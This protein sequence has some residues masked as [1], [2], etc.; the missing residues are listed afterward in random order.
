MMDSKRTKKPERGGPVAVL[1]RVGG[2]LLSSKAFLRV[3]SVVAALVVWLFMMASDGTLTRRKTF[4]NAAVSVS[5]ESAL[6]TRGYIVTDNLNAILPTVNMTV[7]VTQNNY[8]R[9]NAASY[10]PHIEL[11]HITGEGEFELPIIPT[12]QVYGQMIS[13]EPSTVT[14]HAERYVTRRV[15]VV[16]T[17]Y[18]SLPKGL[19]LVSVEADPATLVVSGPQSTVADVT[20][21]S[22]GLDLSTLTAD[23]L[24][25]RLSMDFSLQNAAGETVTSD[26]MSVTNQSVV[27]HS[28]M[29]DVSMVPMKRVPID[30]AALVTG[31]PAEGYELVEAWAAEDTLDVAA[32]QEIL[33]A[34]TVIG[35]DSPLDITGADA[36]MNGYVRLRQLTSVANRLPSQ[37]G[38]TA[39]IKERETERTFRNVPILV[40]GLTDDFTATLSLSRT[41]AQ[42]T[43]GYAFIQ[44]LTA[45][46]LQLYV[47]VAGLSEGKYTLAVQVRV[48]NAEPFS[49]ALSAPE[50]TVQ[51]RTR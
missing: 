49:C 41:T 22:V 14:V 12:S 1:R 50:I 47:D 15:P 35:I 48:D 13:C 9:A 33:D 23:R 40:E 7:E 38:V 18:G 3:F 6:L 30:T 28:V 20:R 29:V 19:Y 17:P 4:T 8:D 42:I 46:S 2:Q 10:N 24:T 26:K 25:D 27:T 51:L 21:V 43:G 36:T 32:D 34:V 45:E 11:T 37:L 5:G 44:S 16:V 39:V 31:E